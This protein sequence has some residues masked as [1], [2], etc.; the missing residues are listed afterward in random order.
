MALDL[1]DAVDPVELTGYTRT[2]LDDMEQNQ[3]FFTDAL[4]TDYTSAVA[5]DKERFNRFFHSM[6][7][8]GVY[9]APA[10]YEAGFVGAAHGPA[11]IEHTL[12]AARTAFAA[13]Q[14]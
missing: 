2:A 1:F 3:F 7:D 4:P 11:E 5:V 10:L 9:F 13:L 12:K 6:L 8:G 14:N